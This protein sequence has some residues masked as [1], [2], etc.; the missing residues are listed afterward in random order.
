MLDA[1]YGVMFTDVL[2]DYT[3]RSNTLNIRP[4]TTDGSAAQVDWDTTNPYVDTADGKSYLYLDNI[5]LDVTK[6]PREIIY[7]LLEAKENQNS[8]YNSSSTRVWDFVVVKVNQ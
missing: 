6:S 4:A 2:H 7:G 5:R 3:D 1:Q 8:A